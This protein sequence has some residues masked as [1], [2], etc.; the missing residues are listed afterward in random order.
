[1]K[2]NILSILDT[3]DETEDIIDLGIKL[4]KEFNNGKKIDYLKGKRLAMIF[5]R[6]SIR[7][8]VSFEFGILRHIQLLHHHNNLYLI[9]LF[10]P[11]HQDE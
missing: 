4:K 5:E 10:F 1:M 8:R 6:A 11:Y 7:T 3:R 9:V 2:K